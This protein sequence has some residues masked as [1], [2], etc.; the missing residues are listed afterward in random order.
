MQPGNESD[1]IENFSW[2]W[3]LQICQLINEKGVKPIDR[4]DITEHE[5]LR[6]LKGWNTLRDLKHLMKYL[7]LLKILEI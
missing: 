5:S 7:K 4:A 6:I 3:L 2:S 1:R